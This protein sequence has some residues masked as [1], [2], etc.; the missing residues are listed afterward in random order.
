MAVMNGDNGQH[1]LESRLEAF[2]RSDQE[3]DA[4]FHVSFSISSP[5]TPCSFSHAVTHAVERAVRQFMGEEALALLM[6]LPYKR[7]AYT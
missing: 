5:G 7:R 3:R 2:R 4:L 6:R 1:T